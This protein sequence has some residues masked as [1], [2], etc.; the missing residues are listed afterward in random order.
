MLLR[1]QEGGGGKGRGKGGTVVYDDAPRG[2]K[3]GEGDEDDLPPGLDTD[4]PTALRQFAWAYVRGLGGLV[5]GVADMTYGGDCRER[6]RG[7]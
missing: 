6:G 2:G 7:V 5:M 1:K 3:D 4:L